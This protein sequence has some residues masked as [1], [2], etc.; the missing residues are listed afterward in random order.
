MTTTF[1]HLLSTQFDAGGWRC[2]KFSFGCGPETDAADPG[3]TLTAALDAFRFT[4]H[5]A[6]AQ[7]DAAVE[8]LL[9]H[10]QTRAPLG[11]C[12]YGIGNRFL[13]VGYP[14][15]G[16]NLFPWAYV[17]SF[18]DRAKGDPRFAEALAALEAKLQDGQVVPERVHRAL[19]SLHFCRKG[20]PSELATRRYREILANLGR[21]Q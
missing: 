16:Y 3:P 20:A 19:A 18:Y 9:G 11:P 10:W 4:G 13:Q 5:N 8:L 17:L 15:A 12:H 7:L 2:N 21:P 6:L 14:F 1:D